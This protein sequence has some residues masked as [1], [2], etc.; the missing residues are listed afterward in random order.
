MY[1]HDCFYLS[2]CVI[3]QVFED[4]NMSY[5]FEIMIE[6]GYVLKI[7]FLILVFMFRRL[8]RPFLHKLF[9]TSVMILNHY[10]I[11][12]LLKSFIKK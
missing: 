2:Q 10:H 1:M 6:G 5:D 11:K 3:E 9:F 4:Q 12:Q 8:K 7:F